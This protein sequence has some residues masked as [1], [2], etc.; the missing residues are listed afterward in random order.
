[1]KAN[2]NACIVRLRKARREIVLI[3]WRIRR[4]S[5]LPGRSHQLHF[6]YAGQLEGLCI[7]IMVLRDQEAKV[8]AVLEW[9]VLTRSLRASEMRRARL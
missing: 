8:K 4:R 7:A 9:N 2:K 3:A 6:I 5:R 1:M